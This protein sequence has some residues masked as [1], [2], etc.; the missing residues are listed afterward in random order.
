MIFKN[1]LKCTII[2]VATL[3][4]LGINANALQ[5]IVLF[6]LEKVTTMLICLQQQLMHLLFIGKWDIIPIMQ[7]TAQQKV[8]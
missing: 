1:F 5:G 6:R 8:F 2:G 7:L 3:S 4:I